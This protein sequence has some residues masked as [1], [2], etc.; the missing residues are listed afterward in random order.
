MSKTIVRPGPDWK[1][2]LR[3]SVLRVG[4]QLVLTRSMLEMLCAVAD[5]VYW[6]RFFCHSL[7]VPDNWIAT[8]VALE[9]RGLIRRKTA[10]VIKEE[11]RE[12]TGF[13][14][15]CELTPAG[16][17]VVELAKMSGLFIEADCAAAKRRKA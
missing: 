14:S 17:A 10:K 11:C 16:S 13:R 7:I 8:E 3:H 12:Q 6:D 15:N 4:F 5:D 1:A 9:R 2:N